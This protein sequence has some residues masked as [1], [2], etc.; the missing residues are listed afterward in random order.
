MVGA[1]FRAEI[2]HQFM[3]NYWDFNSLILNKGTS[4]HKASLIHSIP[5]GF[6]YVV[7]VNYE[8]ARL[9]PLNQYAW[10]AVVLDEG[11]RIGQYN[12]KQTLA[13]T[14]ML[15]DVPRK[16][17]MTGT[18]WNDGYERLYS[19]VRF[20]DP[21]L[22]K[23]GHPRSKIF[24]HRNDFLKNYCHTYEMSRGIHIIN[25][26]KNTDDLATK[27]SPFTL[28][29]KAADVLDLPDV[30]ERVYRVPLTGAVKRAY[31]SL[32]KESAIDLGNDQYLTTSH[33]LTK[34]IRLQQ[35]ATSGLMV[36]DDGNEVVF[37]GIEQRLKTLQMLLDD[38]HGPV[39]VFTRFKRDVQLIEKA[40]KEHL[41][42]LTG[43]IDTHNDWRQGYGRILVANIGA[44]SEGVRLERAAHIIFWSVGYSNTSFEQAKA[45][46]IR[47]GQ[48]S[49]TVWLHYIV[50]EDTIDEKI[51]K[52][53]AG[54]NTNKRR[55][56]ERI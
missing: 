55:L 17:I 22:P 10:A 47:A 12:S 40:T 18:P 29:I 37:K 23:H 2:S 30:V 38:I 7:I 50:S 11:H 51:Y 54:K 27:I 41:H 28:Q 1:I 16:C 25:G 26:Y 53:L 3:G 13:L 43:D 35:L 19:M 8:T 5:P 39:V 34:T 46:V 9:L 48:T 33:L 36:S 42:Y 20:L 21:V 45:R 52:T 49:N 32:E 4:K 44:G 31:K 14:T 56:D 15:A 6:N 24:G